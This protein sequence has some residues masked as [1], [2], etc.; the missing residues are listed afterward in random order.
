MAVEKTIKKQQDN[1]LNVDYIVS[2]L[3]RGN[4][5]FTY[6][7]VTAS[8]A[9]VTIKAGMVMGRISATKKLVPLAHGAVDGSQYPVG[10]AWLGI[11]G[12]KTVLDGTT[13]TIEAVYQGKVDAGLINF[14][15]ASTLDDLVDGRTVRDWLRDVGLVLE[16]VQEQTNVAN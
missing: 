7:D 12:E 14:G 10:L 6:G 4:N 3:L 15:T 2:N 5:E 1:Q 8:G 16:D 11:N 13:K 9:D